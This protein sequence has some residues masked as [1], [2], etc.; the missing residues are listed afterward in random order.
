[1]NRVLML[2]GLD[3]LPSTPL[4]FRPLM[5]QYMSHNHTYTHLTTAITAITITAYYYEKT[6][7]DKK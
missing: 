3:R 4:P 7:I 2:T 5:L 1:M 6:K